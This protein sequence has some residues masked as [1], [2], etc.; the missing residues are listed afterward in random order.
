MLTVHRPVDTVPLLDKLNADITS[1]LRIPEVV[2]RLNELVIPPS[3]TSHEEF[4]ETDY[5]LARATV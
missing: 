5:M 3:P 1:V 2:Q 4:V